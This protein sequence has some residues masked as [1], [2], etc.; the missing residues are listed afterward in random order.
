VAT[1]SS[2][3]QSLL[4]FY[5]DMLRLRNARQSLSQGSYES[6]FVQGK[7]MGYQRK[8]GDEA[9]MVLINYGRKSVVVR[10]P[11][12]PPHSKWVQLYPVRTTVTARLAG[13][14][15]ITLPA[16]SVGVYALQP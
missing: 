9:T 6:P 1:Q 12:V 7:A 11:D 5:K 13:R 15:G 14:A 10:A 4:S 8:L 16:Q 2:D 3:T